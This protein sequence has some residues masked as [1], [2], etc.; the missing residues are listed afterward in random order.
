M[1]GVDLRVVVCVVLVVRLCVTCFSS[2]EMR[3]A[4][5]LGD[6]KGATSEVLMVRLCTGA[7]KQSPNTGARANNTLHKYLGYPIREPAKQ[8]ACEARP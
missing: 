6:G 1:R 3:A 8:S 5:R 2:P 7:K 4:G